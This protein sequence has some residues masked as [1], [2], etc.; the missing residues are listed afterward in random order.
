MTAIFC[1][2]VAPDCGY[3]ELEMD[4]DWLI[5]GILAWTGSSLPHVALTRL[6]VGTPR[7]CWKGLQISR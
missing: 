4:V 6:L 2:E 5:T 3:T 7:E 1:I